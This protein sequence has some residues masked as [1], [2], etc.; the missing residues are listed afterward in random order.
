MEKTVEEW[1]AC[2]NYTHI[3]TNPEIAFSKKFKKCILDQ[4]SFTN[5]LCLL[6]I[7]E[8]HF[9]KEW[10]K[11]FWPMYAEIEKVWK[12]IQC[13]I[14]FLGVFA[15]MTKF[16]R[17]QVIAKAGFLPDY[18]LM[19]TSLDQSEIMQILLPKKLICTGSSY[20]IKSSSFSEYWQHSFL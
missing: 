17:S 11:S 20:L 13:H 9:I 8:I 7:D 10:G 4:Q 14:P 5:C 2:K 18:R 1:V 12:K 3:F 6:A 16:V 15:T 19:Q